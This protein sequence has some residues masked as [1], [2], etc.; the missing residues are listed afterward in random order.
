MADRYQNWT[1]GAVGGFLAERLGLP[2]P[3]V[4]RRFEPGRPA[5]CGPVALGGAGRLRGDLADV[6]KAARI[7]VHEPSAAQTPP[8]GSDTPRFAGLVFDATGLTDTAALS[9]I[10][11]FF[12]AR[13]RALEPCARVVVVGTLPEKAGTGRVAQRALEGFTRS[14][15]KELRRGAT[16]NLVLVGPDTHGTGLASTVRFL[17]SDRSAYVSGQVLRLDSLLPGE[18]ADDAGGWDWERPLEDKAAVVTGAARGIGAVIAATLARDGASVVCVDVPGQSGALHEVAAR[19]GGRALELD[20]T[21]A[22][23]GAVLAERLGGG[24]RPGID[25]FVHNAGVL[26]DKTLGRME[27]GQWDTV[28]AVNLRAVETL[29][30]R[31]L[32]QGDPLLR[33]GGRIVCT[34]SIAGIAGNVGQTNYAASKAGLI[35][36]V[37]GL[38]PE[39]AG[40]FGGTVNA[41]APG[42]IETRM[43]ASVPLAIREAGRR[44]NSLR[45][46]GQPVDVAEAVAFLAAPGSGS[47]NGQTLR[48]CGQSLLGA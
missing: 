45:Q 19:I 32:D 12:H 16:A 43:T 47:I 36:L 27:R 46:G 5:P 6:L 34:S 33:R 18:N 39:L 7:D 21:D 29:T 11:E 35:G 48:V 9:E 38:A 3:E 10:Y 4:L 41:V 44:M 22:A 40:R 8:Y 31:L 42:F 17:L 1:R 23:A 13:I 26:R 37:E 20:I 15:A 30:R 2:K 25:V 28:L 24:G 14:M